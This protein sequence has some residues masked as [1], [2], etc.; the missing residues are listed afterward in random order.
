MQNIVSHQIVTATIHIN[1]LIFY[2]LSNFVIHNVP[3]NVPFLNEIRN[4]FTILQQ[5]TQCA[6]T[7]KNK[8]GKYF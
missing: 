7:T 4:R 2:L 5:H 3:Y 1:N 8:N 6:F